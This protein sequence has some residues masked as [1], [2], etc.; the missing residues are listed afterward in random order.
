MESTTRKIAAFLTDNFLVGLLIALFIGMAG[1]IAQLA[2]KIP[3]SGNL[4]DLFTAITMLMPP[5]TGTGVMTLIWW[6]VSTLVIGSI[7]IAVTK[8]R[9]YFVIFDRNKQPK[10]LSTK[11]TIGGIVVLGT[12]LSFA[13]W[14]INTIFGYF[15]TGL[16]STDIR[17]IYAALMAGNIWNFVAGIAFAIIIG[18]LVSKIALSKRPEQVA[19]D[20][21]LSKGNL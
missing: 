18:W 4:Q 2:L 15:G 17:G 6:I 14:V 13:F 5:N 8:Y 1:G 12:F 21:S 11:R 9:R 16:A 7:S 3:L 19:S 20:L 10:D